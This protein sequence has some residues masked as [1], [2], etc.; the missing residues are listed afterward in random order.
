MPLGTII[1]RK[2]RKIMGN[3]R[4]KN[5][6]LS[7]A[8]GIGVR[9]LTI[10]LNFVLK[11]VFIKLL[12]IQ[13]T[14]VSSLFS[15]ILTVLSFA[16]LGIGSAI[17]YALYKPVAENDE[18][19]IA[20]IMNFYKSAYRMV[21][22]TVFF[23]GSLLIP[24]LD[25]LVKDVPDI[26]ED[27]RLIYFLYL[28]NTTCSY[29]LIYKSSI[30]N[31][32]QKKY[33]ISKIEG[34]MVV[35]RLTVEFIVL[36]VFREFLLYLII[37]LIMTIIKNLLIARKAN[38]EYVI[39]STEKLH[40]EEKKIIFADIG[41]LAMY[42]ISYV[43]ASGTDSIIISAILGTGLVGYLSYYKMILSQI[44]MV[45]QQFFNSANASIG[46]LAVEENG[47]KQFLLFKSIDFAVFWLM[48]ICSTGLYVLF[49]PFVELWLGTEYQLSQGIVLVLIIDF[50]IC[51][52]IRVVASFR[53]ANGLF[54]QGKYRPVIM[55]GL[56]I[57]LS[58]LGAYT[59]GMF[60][61][62]LATIISRVLT[63]VW[64]DPWLIYR[65]VFKRNVFEY[66]KRYIC[67]IISFIISI[68]CVVILCSLIHVDNLLFMFVLKFVFC[69]VV[70]DLVVILLWHKTDEYK[71]C[72]NR[73]KGIVKMF[74]RKR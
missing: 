63:Q 57:A 45:I 66:Y 67:Y 4:T 20:K 23:I 38:Q 61:V 41:A 31:A 59:L 13:Y 48:T 9:V 60:G 64:Y 10:I 8:S 19:Q 55:A 27:I 15:D 47:N 71:E 12:G 28:L 73:I 21:A 50:V 56:N 43:V 2:E 6:L 58:V 14:G 62:L 35:V 11:T 26:K 24:F 25:Y 51:N 74:K 5:V 1:E 29:L 54:V 68:A 69:V 72:C 65:E 33:E 30:L 16:E 17:T 52:L 70:S 39:C 7:T 49:N 18:E 40:I 53:T 34:L 32:K 37:E 44:T 42:Q 46:N 36:V 22:A 3:S